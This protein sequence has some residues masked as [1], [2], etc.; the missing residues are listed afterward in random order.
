MWTRKELKTRAKAA[1]KMYYWKMVLVAFIL[2]VVTGGNSGSS[3][4]DYQN[5]GS[6]SRTGSLFSSSGMTM[7]EFASAMRVIAMTFAAISLVT[8]LARIF[9]LDLLAAGCRGFFHHGLEKEPDLSD[10]ASVFRGNY[11][12]GV[13]VCFLRN[14]Y[15]ALWTLLFVIPGIVKSYEYRMVPYLLADN[16]DMSSNEIFARSKELMDGN[17][18]DAFVLDLSFLGWVLLSVCTL[19]VLHIFWVAPYI[20]ATD[21]ALYRKLSG[22]D[23][24]SYAG[25]DTGSPYGNASDAWGYGTGSPYGNTD[26]TENNSSWY[27]TQ[28]T[29][30]PNNT[31]P[32]FQKTM[33][34]TSA[35]TQNEWTD[36]VFDQSYFSGQDN[37]SGDD[38]SS[39]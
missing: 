23:N 14:L 12:N 37:P 13:K 16:P 36:G 21:A 9:A 20:Y 32:P 6:S 26:N 5:S 11:W 31:Q 3:I 7:T 18:W 2:S 1:I 29:G 25:Y 34:N 38:D 24:I 35:S 28:P 39:R 10:I 15:I 27:G 4:G 8:I 22:A 33:D 30:T 19:G 17:K